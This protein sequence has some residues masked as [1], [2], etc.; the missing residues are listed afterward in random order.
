MF[1]TNLVV[2]ELPEG[3]KKLQQE[4]VWLCPVTETTITVPKWFVTD[5]DSVPRLPVIY[6]LFKGLSTRPPVLHDFLYS[7]TEVKRSDADSAFLIAMREE[8]VSLIQRLCIFYAVR[9]FGKK[10]RYEAYGID[11]E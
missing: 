1:L 5:Y 7:S 11:N 4:L 3:K 10:V 9:V 8:G 6:A 2:E